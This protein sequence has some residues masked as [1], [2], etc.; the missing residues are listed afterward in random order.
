MEEIESSDDGEQ[1][2]N[3]AVNTIL[4]DYMDVFQTAEEMERGKVWVDQV[5]EDKNDSHVSETPEYGQDL[6]V[7]V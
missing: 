5:E 2:Y 3:V 1:I 4:N 6:P 7:H